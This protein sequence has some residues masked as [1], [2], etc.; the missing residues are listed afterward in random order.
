MVVVF[1][2]L[3]IIS[4][5]AVDYVIQRKRNIGLAAKPKSAHFTLGQVL[6][7]IPGGVFLQPSFTWSRI[8][9][10]GNLQV[11]VNPILLGLIGE[12]DE[13]ILLPDG[14]SVKKGETLLTLRK[15]AQKLS[16]KS[17]FEGVVTRLNQAVL[18][19][20]SWRNVSQNWLYTVTPVNIAAEINHWFI[21][22][23]AQVWLNEK[24]DQ[25]KHFLM[26][27]TSGSEVGLT[28]ADGGDIPAG[29]LTQFDSAVW[30]KFETE[31]I[32]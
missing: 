8:Q 31:F 18:R 27:A 17:P 16:V 6:S 32:K 1:V 28:M 15:G 9:E 23:K 26:Q 30:Q 7:L 20:S 14:Q 11:G 4:F 10:N 24:F 12:P 13:I 29:I 22:E 5:V 21:A 3:T 19:D 25:I 2:L